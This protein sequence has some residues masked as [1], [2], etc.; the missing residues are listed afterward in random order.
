MTIDTHAMKIR[1]EEELATL[2]K[3]LEGLGI[4]NP[5]TKED[6][7]PTP[8]DV[9]TPEA[10]QN[11]VADRSEDW[12]ERRGTLDALETRYNNIVRALDAI[13]GGTYGI[14]EI[15]GEEIEADRLEANPAARTCKAHITDEAS[16]LQ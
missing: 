16:L 13:A 9:G 5:Q 10:D 6:W 4:H 2:T 15:G 8:K 1:L 3:E 12:A 11:V 14:C 7:I